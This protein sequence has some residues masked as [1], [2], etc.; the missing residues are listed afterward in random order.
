VNFLRQIQIFVP[1]DKHS[2]IIEFLQDNLGL[3]NL[4]SVKGDTNALISLR[5]NEAQ[6]RQI[7][8]DLKNIGVGVEY[9]LID[10][11]PI[12][13]SVPLIE[14]EK[15]DLLESSLSL[16]V[17]TEELYRSITADA[18]ISFDY[19]WFIVISALVAGLGILQDSGIT[20]VASMLLAP[21]MGPILGFSLSYVTRDRQLSRDSLIAEATGLV[22]ALVCGLVLGLVTSRPDNL[23]I[24]MASRG[25]PG[26]IDLFIALLSGLAV[27]YALGRGTTSSLVGVAI[28]A[29][30]MPPAVN[31][32]IAIMWR[33]GSIALGSL[34]LLLANIII[35]D[36]AAI[37][38]FTIMKIQPVGVLDATWTGL[39][40]EQVGGRFSRIFGRKRK[41]KPAPPHESETLDIDDA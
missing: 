11:L 1:K 35:I 6:S 19:L 10:V 34:I 7:V 13:V 5:V 30:L 39:S 4:F 17:V 32:G 2:E 33:E 22:L 37:G 16:R 23:P 26:L 38:M 3:A 9:G 18:R 12:V 40:E 28:A 15:E 8:E 29:S 20:V 21:L 27:T 31:V 24:Q 41:K 14:E 36:I 25:N